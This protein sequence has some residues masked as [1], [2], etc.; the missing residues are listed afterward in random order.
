[1]SYD[2]SGKYIWLTFLMKSVSSNIKTNGKIYLH[3]IYLTNTILTSKLMR[4]CYN[5]ELLNLT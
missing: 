4:N 5:E 3:V 1:M 2:G